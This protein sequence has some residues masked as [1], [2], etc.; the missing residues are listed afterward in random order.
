MRGYMMKYIPKK[1]LIIGR[2]YKGRCRNATE[3]VWVGGYFVYERRKFDFVYNERINHPEDD[4]GFDLFY[5]QECLPDK[6]LKK[7]ELKTGQWYKGFGAAKSAMWI[8]DRF[9]YDTY[10]NGEQEERE[11][12]HPD[13]KKD[14]VFIVF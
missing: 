14:P 2:K 6:Y 9:M 1:D 10:Q 3:A 12:Y 13:D 8:G 5:A 7:Y 11:A 4:N